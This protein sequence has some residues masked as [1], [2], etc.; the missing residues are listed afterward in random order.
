MAFLRNMRGSAL[1]FIWI[2]AVKNVPRRFGKLERRAVRC[3]FGAGCQETVRFCFGAD[4]GGD[5]LLPGEI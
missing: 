2:Q 5:G 3:C 1:I 4:D